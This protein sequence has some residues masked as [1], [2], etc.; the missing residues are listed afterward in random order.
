MKK[1]HPISYMGDN[2][3]GE[4]VSFEKSFYREVYL[5]V[6]VLKYQTLDVFVKYLS[7]LDARIP[8]HVELQWM[9]YIKMC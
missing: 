5:G 2:I 6:P 7:F 8:A 4:M 3:C 1:N 9:K